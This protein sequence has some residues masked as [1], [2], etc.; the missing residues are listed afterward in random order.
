MTTATY[1]LLMY[2]LPYFSCMDQ[3]GSVFDFFDE[4]FREAA[5][6]SF[7]SEN[8]E[9]DKLSEGWLNYKELSSNIQGRH[10]LLLSLLD[11]VHK[12]YWF[13]RSGG[14]IQLSLPPSLAPI[15]QPAPVAS[16]QLLS[17]I[18][19]DEGEEMTRK[20]VI[21]MFNEVE[22]FTM[23]SGTVFSRL[24]KNHT[25]VVKSLVGFS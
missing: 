5:A 24:K 9:S 21:Q 23:M 22:D 16:G 11:E 19:T 2:I 1:F 3:D 7:K 4:G 15:D 6:D 10:L 14:F 17:E 25:L 18:R 13:P 8:V 20:Q 12:P